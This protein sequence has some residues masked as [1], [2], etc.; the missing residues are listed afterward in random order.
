MKKVLTGAIKGVIAAALIAL[1]IYKVGLTDLF[2]TFLNVS[3]ESIVYLLVISFILVLVSAIKW[4]LFLQS[5]G[6]KVSVFRLFN[7]YLVG[8][9]I[10]L[11]IPSFVGG[12]AVRSFYAGKK[13][14][15]HQAFAATI[16]ERYTGVVAMLGLALITMWFVSAVTWQIKLL[17]C[18]LVFVLFLVTVALLSEYF[19]KILKLVRIPEKILLNFNK[20]KA[21]LNLARSN[22][23]LLVKAILLSLLFHTFT[24]VNTLA[25]AHAVGWY[26]PPVLDIFVV[27]PIILLIGS[28]PITPGGLG[29]QEGAFVFFLKGLGATTS[30]GL[31]L[32]LLL[33]A[34]TYVLALVGGLI[35]LGMKNH[36]AKD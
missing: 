19:N 16:L 33:R 21:G 32:S 29:I 18:G 5:S 31:A 34:K 7:L 17:V 22:K 28:L 27:L 10:N 12:D 14:G 13:V 4:K 2:D 6:E 25:A 3:I 24:V 20:V 11:L 9:F 26:N 30:Q 1:L 8:Y 36:K 15:Q 23:P 35:W